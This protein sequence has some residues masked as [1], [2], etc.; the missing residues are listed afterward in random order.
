MKESQTKV[1]GINN[2]LTVNLL[3][4][5]F[6]I[7]LHQPC[8]SLLV[9]VID[10]LSRVTE[11]ETFRLLVAKFWV[12]ISVQPLFSMFWILVSTVRIIGGKVSP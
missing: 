2:A 7:F 9:L 12:R 3:R 10:A 5:Y 4:R 6:W 1:A 11:F 8:L